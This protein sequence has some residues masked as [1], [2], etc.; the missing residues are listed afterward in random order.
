MSRYR[1]TVDELESVARKFWPPELITTELE[2]S[3]IPRLL[4]TQEQFLAILSVEVP[5]IENLFS[6]IESSTMPANL[7]VK[8]LVVLADFGGEMLKRIKREFATL[9]PENR[10]DYVWPAAGD[11]VQ[12]YR[13]AE[14]P[15]TA[16]SNSKLDITSVRLRKTIPLSPLMKDIIALLLFG[17][18]SIDDKVAEVL[19]KCEISAYLGQPDKLNKFIRE[20]YILVSRITGGATSNQLGHLTQAYVRSFLESTLTIDG[21]R[22]H[23]NGHIPGITHTGESDVR[24]TTFDLVLSNQNRYLAV[25]ISFQVTTN[26]VIERKSGQA[27]S[28]YEQ[29]QEQ[30]HKIAYILDG[31]G[32]FERQSALRTIVAYSDCTV[33]FTDSELELLCEFIEAYFNGTLI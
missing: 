24:E 9:F 2:A 27:R 20:R 13:F 21:L 15:S 22:F 17:S 30:G 28:R 4:E 1:R 32:N 8:H 3:I 29:L 16:V 23:S 11:R 18:S 19:S 6:I 12:S 26:S 25:E 14:L 33:A 5:N 10:L 31:A 7:F